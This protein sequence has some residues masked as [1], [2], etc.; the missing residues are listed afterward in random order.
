LVGRVERVEPPDRVSQAVAADLADLVE[1]V[2]EL[3]A[4]LEDRALDAARQLELPS[5]FERDRAAVAL[6]R[7]DV[8]AVVVRLPAKAAGE[9]GE[10]IT[11][12][13]GLVVAEHA[14]VGATEDELLVL[15]ADEPSL[16]RLLANAKVLEE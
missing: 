16:A 12:A 7:D 15:G 3:V 6:E 8:V 14:G 9:L 4:G 13:A 10:Q 2:V 11:K 1:V 5:G